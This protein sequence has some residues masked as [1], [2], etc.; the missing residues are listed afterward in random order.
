MP[1]YYLEGIVRW[2]TFSK[3]CESRKVLSSNLGSKIFQ[4]VD[5]TKSCSLF[6]ARFCSPLVFFVFPV[7]PC[8]KHLVFQKYPL[9]MESRLWI[10]LILKIEILHAHQQ[11]SVLCHTGLQTVPNSYLL[12]TIVREY[13]KAALCDIPPCPRT[14]VWTT[15][16]II[17]SLETQ[18]R[19]Y[20][21]LCHDTWHTALK[22][23]YGSLDWK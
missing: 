7:V 22:W 1:H 20:A 11:I 15:V 2:L 9:D 12:I 23:E 10:R 4:F 16:F 13:A 14:T 6:F 17:P 5:K 19:F 18:L 21:R 8:S 3:M